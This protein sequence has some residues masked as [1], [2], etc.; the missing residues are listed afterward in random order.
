MA[1]FGKKQKA[2]PLS[3]AKPLSKP[4]TIILTCN[5]IPSNKMATYWFEVKLNDEMVGR[6]EQNG[7][8]TAFTTTVDKNALWM[9]LCIKENN[10]NITKYPTS[11]QV[12]ELTDGATVKVL[13]EKR[14]FS[15]EAVQA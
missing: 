10:G 4:A 14:K 5:A 2:S 15:V 11:T 13:F 8:P 1:L 7:T 6:I 9:D 3:A 12:L